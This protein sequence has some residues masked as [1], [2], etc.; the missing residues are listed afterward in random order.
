MFKSCEVIVIV[1]DI[2]FID[3]YH[4]RSG[5][6]DLWTASFSKLNEHFIPIDSNSVIR[7]LHHANKNLMFFMYHSYVFFL[8][9]L[10][11]SIGLMN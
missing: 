3:I 2:A 5:I 1:P 8:L 7:S 11:N 6:N 4:I 9:F 10:S